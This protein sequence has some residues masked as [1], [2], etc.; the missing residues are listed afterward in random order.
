MNK[1][2]ITGKTEVFMYVAIDKAWDN[3]KAHWVE[4]GDNIE[5]SAKSSKYISSYLSVSKV[6]PNDLVIIYYRDP[7]TGKKNKS[8]FVSVA[9]IKSEFNSGLP[10]PNIFT[11]PNANT[12]VL[13]IYN[14]TIFNPIKLSDIFEQL[15]PADGFSTPKSFTGKYFK[16]SNI[17]AP[18]SNTLGVAIVRYLFKLM[19]IERPDTETKTSDYIDLSDDGISSGSIGGNNIKEINELI[20]SSDSSSSGSTTKKIKKT[21]KTVRAKGKSKPI[22]EPE[23][24]NANPEKEYGDGDGS[25]GE[26]C[27]QEGETIDNSGSETSQQPTEDLKGNVPVMVELCKKAIGEITESIDNEPDVI[28]KHLDICKKCNIIDNMGILGKIM[29]NWKINT[30]FSEIDESEEL[31]ETLLDAYYNARPYYNESETDLYI[32]LLFVVDPDCEYDNC[33]IIDSYFPDPDSDN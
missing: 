30:T 29:Q 19:C 8:G 16:R 23:I 17:F 24:S 22:S 20:K 1:F 25:E 12:H 10:K 11:D 2:G 31:Y 9:Q 14:Q 7:A 3:L 28:Y 26:D 32:K 27:D 5:G 15:T 4:S 18:L 13:E 6:K 33:I 21:K